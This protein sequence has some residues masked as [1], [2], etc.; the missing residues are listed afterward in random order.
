MNERYVTIKAKKYDK[1]IYKNIDIQTQKKE[2][3]NYL[4]IAKNVVLSDEDKQIILDDLKYPGWDLEIINENAQK[5]IW[6]LNF[7]KKS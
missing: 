1:L 5:K 4:Y 2:T 6:P 7:I 3:F